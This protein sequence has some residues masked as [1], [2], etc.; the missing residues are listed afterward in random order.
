MKK[1]DHDRV[2]ESVVGK[3]ELRAP[4]IWRKGERAEENKPWCKGLGTV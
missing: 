3:G 4:N 2:T 1:G